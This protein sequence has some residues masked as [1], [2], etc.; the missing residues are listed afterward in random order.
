MRCDLLGL[1]DDLFGCPHH[2]RPAH[3]NRAAAIGAHAHRR[4]GSVA[5]H[6]LDHIGVNSDHLGHHLCERGLMPLPVAVTT[7]HDH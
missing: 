6:D 7:G 5:M 4:I 3:G 2:G 1:V